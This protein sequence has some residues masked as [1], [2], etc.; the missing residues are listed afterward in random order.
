MM[1]KVFLEA[2]QLPAC[3]LV[4]ARQQIADAS[5]LVIK[6]ERMVKEAERK[7]EDTFAYTVVLASAIDML[8]RCER[9]AIAILM[10]D[11]K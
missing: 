10:G 9:N 1:E 3:A 4:V 7:G 2:M 6:M 8:K 5:L 11:S